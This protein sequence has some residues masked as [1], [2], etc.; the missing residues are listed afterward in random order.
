LDP[1]RIAMAADIEEVVAGVAELAD[2]ET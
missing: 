2:A 1:R